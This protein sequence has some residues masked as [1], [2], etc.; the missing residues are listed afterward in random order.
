MMDKAEYFGDDKEEDLLS[1]LA[2]VTYH[3][4]RERSENHRAFFGRWDVA[5]RKVTEHK[6]NLPDP[7]VGFLM[8]NALQIPEADIKNLLNYTRGSISPKDVREWVRKH[9]TKLQV[10]QVGIDPKKVIKTNATLYAEEPIDPDE[11]ELHNIEEALRD[12]QGDDG[13]TSVGD[14][15]EDEAYVLEEH[16]A[17]EV[18]SMMVQKKKTFMQNLQNKKSRELGRGYRGKPFGASSSSNSTLTRSTTSLKPGRYHA[19]IDGQ[20][21]IEELKKITRCGNCKQV[22]HWWKECPKKKEK[23]AHLVTLDNPPEVESEEATF[24]GLVE[25][26]P[27]EDLDFKETETHDE[28]YGLH[29]AEEDLTRSRLSRDPGEDPLFLT[30]TQEPVIR[31]AMNGRDT[32]DHFE[33]SSAKEAYNDRC[34]DGYHDVLF[35]EGLGNL[36]PKTPQNP[37][38]V[39]EDA[40]ATIDTGCQRMAIGY[41]TLQKLA[42]HVPDELSVNLV[43]QTHKFRSVH[44]RS[45]T[46]HVAS[47]PTSVGPKGSLLRPAVFENEESRTA[48]FLISLPFL[49]F[50]RTVLYL[51]PQTGLKAHFRRLHF[52]VSCHLGPTGALRIPLCEFDKIK[53]DKVKHAQQK[54]CEQAGEF[55]VLRVQETSP[56]LDPNSNSC[57]LNDGAALDEA[58][59]IRDACSARPDESMDEVGSQ[60]DV[61]ASSYEHHGL[62]ADPEEGLTGGHRGV[63]DDLPA[64]LPESSPSRHMEGPGEP[65]Q[66]KTM[67]GTTASE[68]IR[69]ECGEQPFQGRLPAAGEPAASSS[70]T[71]S[72]EC[73][74]TTTRPYAGSVNKEGADVTSC[75]RLPG[76]V[77]PSPDTEGRSQLQTSVLEVPEGNQQAMRVL[78][79]VHQP[80]DVA[81]PCGGWP[82]PRQ[83]LRQGPGGD[84]GE[85]PGQMPSSHDQPV[86]DECVQEDCPLHLMRTGPG[87]GIDRTWLAE[88][89]QQAEEDL[90]A[91]NGRPGL[92]VMNKRG[93]RLLKQ[94]N[95]AL[96]EAEDMWKEL[97]TLVGRSDDLY[98]G[99]QHLRAKC[100]LDP[101]TQRRCKK[102]LKQAARLLGEPNM[103]LDVVAEIFNPK[104]FGPQATSTGLR[105][106]EA[107]D[108][109]LGHDLLKASERQ[110]VR[111]YL[112]TVK[113]GFTCVS[114]PCVMYSILQ[115]LNQ[116]YLDSPEK[117]REH[118]RRM[119]EARILMDFGAEVC[120]LVASYGGTFLFEQP[121]TSKA[122]KETK[123]QQLLSDLRNQLAKNDQCMFN[124]RSSSGALHRKPTG[125]LT[126]NE[127][128]YKVLNVRC[129]GGHAHEPVL[130]GG[131]GGNKSRLAQNYTDELVK[132]VLEAY[133]RS[134]Q[135]HRREVHLLTSTDYLEDCRY[136]DIMVMRGEKSNYFPEED[137]A[138]KNKHQ[139]ETK[140]VA[141]PEDAIKN[142]EAITNVDA[143]VY[144][145]VTDEHQVLPNDI[146]HEAEE[147]G[148][149]EKKEDGEAEGEEAEDPYRMLPRE[150]PFS[151]AQLVK[152][153]HDGLGH[154]ARDRFI[155]ILKEAK[156]SPEAIREA[157]SL[158]CATC[159]KHA[160]LQPH[161]A[162]APPRQIHFNQIVGVDTLWLPGPDPGGKHKMALN[163]V[164]WATRF[165]MMIPLKDHTPRSARS[166]LLQ[167]IRIFGPPEKVYDD[168]GKEFRGTFAELMEQEAIILDPASLETPEQRGITERAGKTFKEILA[169]TL[170]DISCP[171]WETWH[172][173]VATVNGTINRLSNRSGFSPCQR[174][175]GFNPR[176]PGGLITGGANDH[177]VA[178]RYEIGDAEVQR[179]MRIRQA[180]ATAFH[181]SDCHQALRNALQRGRRRCHEYEVGQTVYF[182][183]KGA[184]RAVKD[185]SS[186]WRGPAKVILTSLPSSVWISFQGYVVKASP[187]HLRLASSEEKMTLT[188]WIDDIASTRKRL[189]ETPQKGYIVLDELP[190][191]A[192]QLPEPSSLV[193]K[194]YIHGKTPPSQIE[195][196]PE[197]EAKRARLSSQPD[198]LADLFPEEAPGIQIPAIPME[199]Q[200][201]ELDSQAGPTEPDPDHPGIESIPETS[202][203]PPETPDR[204]VVRDKPENEEPEPPAKRHRAELLEIY[205]MKLES[206]TATRQR[207]EVRMKTM[208]QE[209]KRK[210][211]KAMAKEVNNNLESGAYEVLGMKESEMVRREKNDKIL[212]SR[213]VLTRKPLEPEDVDKAQKEGI[214]LE[215]EDGIVCKAKARHVMQGFSET[216]AEDLPSTTPQ[217]AKDSVIFTLQILCSNGWEIGNLDFTQAFHAGDKIDRELY[218]EQPP[219]GLGL[220]GLQPRQLLK[221]K[222]TCYGLTDGPYQWYRHISRVLHELDYTMSKADPCLFYLHTG[223]KLTGIIALATDDMVHGGTE[224]H[225]K[226]MNQL[227]SRY[228]M[229]KYATGG[230]R[231]AGKDILKNEDGSFVLHQQFYIEEKITSVPITRERS[232]K[233]YSRCTPE[234]IT[235]L[236]GI[237]GGLSWVAKETR[238]DIAGRVAL[239]QQ[240]MPEPQIF[241][242]LEANQILR[243]L[244]K[245]PALG[246]RIQPIPITHL[247]VGVVTDA[248]WGN[249]EHEQPYLEDNEHDY[250]EETS[251]G[252]LRHHIL[253]RRLKFHPAAAPEGP[254][255]HGLTTSRTTST[256][257]RQEKDDWNQKDSVTVLQE[258]TWTGTTFFEKKK[259]AEEKEKPIQE[260]HLQLNR[261]GSQGGYLVIYYDERM[262]HQTDPQMI[263]IAA[264]KSYKLKRCTVNTLSAECQSMLQGIGQV[265]WHRFMLCET[266]QAEMELHT[267]ERQLQQVPF[268]AV[269]DSRSLYDTI[270]KCRNSSAHIDDKRTAIDLSI[271]KGDLVRTKGQVRWIEGKNMISDSLTKR[272]SSVFL[273][274]IMSRGLWSLHEKGFQSLAD[275]HML[276]AT[277]VAAM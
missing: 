12:L 227:Q 140:D 249:T 145:T 181:Q 141:K 144:A 226:R 167:W 200:D 217:V 216:G 132:T 69:A 117:I 102:S 148:A 277:K 223:G 214:L 116:K 146:Y 239:L 138:F 81:A 98:S 56:A 126:N 261:T 125:W 250:W 124:L 29:R 25:I 156:A 197:P 191:E 90:S 33:V 225:W 47:I 34:S 22:G 7:F 133:R 85:H 88:T 208:E 11:E 35:Q 174:V 114:P 67:E 266:M 37:P 163:I 64:L 78:S 115:N 198:P 176:L 186:F 244:K 128:I 109:I 19:H 168:L 6:I 221:L 108:V 83:D 57:C 276:W 211:H 113:P 112:Q 247:R 136:F 152:R 118:A 100:Q 237:I 173:T 103:K 187:E 202:P 23:E 262:E 204:G 119:V 263:T 66:C 130:G 17:A 228:K 8:I 194:R 192:E 52:T 97:M 16:E 38:L 264:W 87:G 44:G 65:S 59:P 182:W 63:R 160:R 159:E 177:G 234:E 58:Q 122:W 151:L 70:S 271:L 72:N 193:P 154:P 94:A 4:R 218:S 240:C 183:R 170:Y 99:D 110:K 259:V 39:P 49:L 86:G 220:S 166:A 41:D 188:G 253:P 230:G 14:S 106:G 153:A 270:T 84:C 105:E 201:M 71:S 232:R 219:E 251:T 178:S 267:W 207:K 76:D 30:I 31:D 60:G 245:N 15:V 269:T 96:K 54:F 213:F 121:L 184:Q 21:T 139:S 50:C 48:P 46:T 36:G 275:L 171:D 9:E 242:I 150:K 169:K 61:R 91:E 53:L 243:D 229:G 89:S 142:T 235:A 185:N 155:R 246:I 203:E 104:R 45:S 252:W 131:V 260:R 129:S 224:E 134:L 68:F 268:I 80:T 26:E 175:F 190:P 28:P 111:F 236:R 42:Q 127:E 149:E 147:E 13:T 212:K 2:R 241:H 143:T 179:A 92:G 20:L 51:D 157:R 1:S 205:H 107:F 24:C 101:S 209:E 62:R 27:Q 255:L 32:P 158:K 5:M 162:A 265:H 199:P 180:A 161:R 82:L 73:R 273:R 172:E 75:L 77:P 256:P 43:P 258:E 164:D 3:L 274:G 210:F 137:E 238:P 74:R 120:K 215:D 248:S 233:R 40:C 55:E 18:L 195:F 254:D 123:V 272:M 79:V 95:T 257:E 222:K 206:L 10:S 93:K 189:E 196:H 135:T 165:Q 231:F